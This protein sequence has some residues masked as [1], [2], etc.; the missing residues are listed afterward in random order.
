MS[1]A[2]IGSAAITAG[3]GYLASK[4]DKG[5]QQGGGG[6]VNYP[7]FYED[8]FFNKGQEDLYGMGTNFMQG[9]IP[10]YYKGIGESGSPEFEDMLRLNTEDIERSG[11]ETAA[12]MGTRG[13]ATQSNIMKNVRS[14]ATPL[15]YADYLRALE[16]RKGF[17]TD[18]TK[19]VSGVRDAGLSFGGQ[20]NNFSLDLAR[21]QQQQSQFEAE[22]AAVNKKSKD[23]MWSS[24]ISGGMSMAGFMA[25]RPK[26]TPTTTGG[27]SKG[28]TGGGS[29]NAYKDMEQQY[30]GYQPKF[31]GIGT[32]Y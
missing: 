17:L 28:T 8:E 12:R 9:N 29:S 5:S 26:T 14:M 2:M 10:E 7:S 18:G 23:A 16:G 1:W 22:Q 25:G 11:F 20:K 13:G 15:I 32:G 31:K 24:L 30:G 19:M 3:S 6:R 4:G 21:M 27:A